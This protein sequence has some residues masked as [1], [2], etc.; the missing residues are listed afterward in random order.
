[1]IYFTQ[2]RHRQENTDVTTLGTR[3]SCLRFLSWDHRGVHWLL[4]ASYVLSAEEARKDWKLG[5]NN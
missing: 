3:M 4:G 5:K 2:L 1:M